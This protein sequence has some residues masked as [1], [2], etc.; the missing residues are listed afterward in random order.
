MI[1]FFLSSALLVIVAMALL[2]PVFHRS[3]SAE[4]NRTD[5]NVGIAKAQAR[6]LKQRLES[7]EISQQDY[8]DEKT[9][10][11]A[12]LARD[13]EN[14]ET[15]AANTHGRWL[16]WPLAVAFPIAAG[17]LYLTLGTPEALDPSSYV[18][19][20][21]ETAQQSQQ[22]QQVPDM[23]TIMERIKLQLEET[24]DNAQAWFMLGRGHLTLGE[25]TQAETA[26]RKSYE[27]DASNID[28]RIRLADAIALG[29]DGRLAGEPTEI[30]IDTLEIQPNHPQGLWLYGIC[31]LYTS[32]AADE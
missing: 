20:A 6:E 19:P 26:L 9:R 24:P 31:L 25:Y 3:A 32:D 2:L 11:E 12:G 15:L 21:V 29:Q 17:A 7:G 1:L 13:I 4:P 16:Q 27:L 28:V 30:L 8:E 10:L 14:E 22:S 5:I 18:R 23:Q